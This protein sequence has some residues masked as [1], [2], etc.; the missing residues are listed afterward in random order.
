MS[1]MQQSI[2]HDKKEQ[3]PVRHTVVIVSWVPRS[4][5]EVVVQDTAFIITQSSGCIR[6]LEL[7]EVEL[8]LQCQ[9]K[10]HKEHPGE[11]MSF[12]LYFRD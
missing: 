8:E 2:G 10:A 12:G 7:A 11:S 4:R 5:M 3:A 1:K 9:A 6:H